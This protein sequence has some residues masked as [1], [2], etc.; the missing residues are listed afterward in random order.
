[1]F[2]NIDKD[3]LIFDLWT[4]DMPSPSSAKL[5][6]IEKQIKDAA[7]IPPSLMKY[8]ILLGLINELEQEIK[9]LNEARSRAI[10]LLEIIKEIMGE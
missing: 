4:P 3:D 5:D 10:R 7:K 8:K 6:K 2:I 9:N 1:M